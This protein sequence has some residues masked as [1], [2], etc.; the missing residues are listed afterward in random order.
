MVSRIFQAARFWCWVET[1][2]DVAL[3]ACAGGT[4]DCRTWVKP[5]FDYRDINAMGPCPCTS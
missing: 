3:G 2:E 4:R 1:S 5:D